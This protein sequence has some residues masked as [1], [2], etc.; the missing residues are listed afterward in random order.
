M[1]EEEAAG[2]VDGAARET[3]SKARSRKYSVLTEVVQ[4]LPQVTVARNF[5]ANSTF[6][7]P[8]PLCPP[9]PLPPSIPSP[10]LRTPSRPRPSSESERDSSTV[11]RLLLPITVAVLELSPGAPPPAP[12]AGRCPATSCP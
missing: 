11:T 8:A 5:P 1:E 12:G 3:T 2:C 7:N 9:R 4:Q 6:T 10:L